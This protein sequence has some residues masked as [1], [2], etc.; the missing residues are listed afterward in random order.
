VLR[1]LTTCVCVLLLMALVACTIWSAVIVTVG[2]WSV[3]LWGGAFIHP[4]RDEQSL[5]LFE[6]RR[7]DQGQLLAIW[8]AFALW[9]RARTTP[10][11]MPLVI[12]GSLAAWLWH[13][14]RRRPAPGACRC[15]YDLTG[16]TSGRCPEC[17]QSFTG[18]A[19]ANQ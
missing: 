2:E 9:P 16:N 17:G 6:F 11:W 7:A 5:S 19:E 3:G 12:V 15:G 4:W 13:L 8:S 1:W 10:L 18:T 14:D